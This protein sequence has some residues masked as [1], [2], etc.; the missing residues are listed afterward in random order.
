MRSTVQPSN[1][2]SVRSE[3]TKPNQVFW[4]SRLLRAGRALPVTLNGDALDLQVTMG[5]LT[6]L[7]TS[8]DY[9]DAC[10]HWIYLL[11]EDGRPID[12]LR[13]PTQ[14]GFIDQVELLSAREMSF[15]YFGSNDRWRLLVDES[16]F[17]SFSMQA[18]RYR[19][20]RFFL[21]KRHLSIVRTKGLPWKT[22][23]PEA[24]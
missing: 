18:L 13:M 10:D 7:A 21:S 24:D 5:R 12:Q 6:V 11:S 20:N 14:F 19:P 1:E 22:A 23:T 9:F 15:G 16:G 8:Y 17:R 4:R 3:P 2:Y